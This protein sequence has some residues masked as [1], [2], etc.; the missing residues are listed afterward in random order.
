MSDDELQLPGDTFAPVTRSAEIAWDDEVDDPEASTYLLAEHGPEPTPDWVITADA[1]RQYELGILKSGK[2]ADVYLVERQLGE[3]IN[4]LAAKRFRSFEDRMFR[5]DARYR[6]TRRSGDRRAD[7]AAGQGTRIGMAVRARQWVETEF[8][9][10]GRLWSAGASVPY[11]VQ[12]LGREILLEYFGSADGAAPRLAQFRC[13]AGQAH[14]LY[15]QFLKNLTILAEQNVVHGDLSAYNLLVW[16]GRLV[17][18]DF[19]QAVDPILNSDGLTL[20]ERDVINA[21]SWFEKHGVI[22]D[23]SA[24]LAELLATILS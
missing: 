21:C 18:I 20:L 4:V 19:P 7:K 3:H 13:S 6:R 8:E 15:R 1:A 9:T 23:P 22:T 5:N 14:D 2:E 12:S 10:L 24:T 17:F 16:E 11:P